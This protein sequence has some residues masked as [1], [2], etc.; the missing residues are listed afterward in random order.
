MNI[1]LID[2]KMQYEYIKGEID[3]AIHSVIKHGNFILGENVKN[4]EEEIARFTD[5]KYGIG[6]ANGTDGLQLTLE[7][8]GI[9]K[10][11]EVITTPFTFATG[12]A[13][14]QVGATP[15]FVDIDEDTYNINV[16]KIEERITNKTK[17]IIPVHLFGQPADMD[18]IVHIGKR[19]D[20]IIIEDACQAMDPS[21]KEERWVL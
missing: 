20:L 9:G 13:I 12:E 1:P 18:K 10:G 3:E 5:T 17:A 2:L 8:Y 14:S 16:N 21:I 11:H 7:A 6:V 19:Y 4:L 15:V